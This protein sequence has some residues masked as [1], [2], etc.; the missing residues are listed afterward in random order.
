MKKTTYKFVYCDNKQCS[1]KCLRWYQNAPFDQM[2]K[3]AR[4]EL[5]KDG[6]C[7]NRIDSILN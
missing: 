6:T 5:K 3:V 7:K 4:Y 1:N 2:I